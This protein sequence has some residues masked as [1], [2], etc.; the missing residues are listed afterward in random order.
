MDD[1]RSNFRALVLGDGEDF[2][3][4]SLSFAGIPELLNKVTERLVAVAKCTH[5]ITG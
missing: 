5:K 3:R 2:D 1:M 4:K